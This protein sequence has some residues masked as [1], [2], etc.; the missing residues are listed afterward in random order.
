[1]FDHEDGTVRFLAFNIALR[2]NDKELAQ[3]LYETEW[4]ASSDHSIEENGWGSCLL[5][6][7]ATPETFETIRKRI[8]P[9]W[10]DKLWRNFDYD[11]AFINPFRTFLS[12]SVEHECNA[13]STRTF[14]EYQCSPADATRKFLEFESSTVTALADRLFDLKR[15]PAMGGYGWPRK[16]ILQA[17]FESDPQQAAIYWRKM[18]EGKESIMG[19]S[20]VFDGMPF[21]GSDGDEVNEL[22][23]VLLK[24][25]KNDWE[26]MALAVA[27]ARHERSAWAVEWI[28]RTLAEPET[29][30]DIARAVTLAGLLDDSVPARELWTNELRKPPLGGWIEFTYFQAKQ[31]IEKAWN[32][33]HWLDQVFAAETDEQFF[34][35]WRLFAL[36]ADYRLVSIASPRLR[37]KPDSMNPRHSDFIDFNWMSVVKQ[38]TNEKNT[39]ERTLFATSVGFRQALPWAR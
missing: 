25:A 26:I 35:F 23:D 20:E 21:A 34:A 11:P 17:F 24:R 38:A 15:V 22:R 27:I 28:K 32:T 6:L 1:M 4:K 8:D 10:S 7:A 33:L 18:D 30:A 39:L 14:P 19:K 9:Q 13:P 12:S 29:S 5:S 36:S 3:R 2:S 37:Q 31:N 16:E